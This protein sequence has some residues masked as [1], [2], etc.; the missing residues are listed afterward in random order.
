MFAGNDE[1]L[2]VTD[3]R[4]DPALYALPEAARLARLPQQ[5]LRNWLVGRRYPAG[6]NLIEGLPVIAV[7]RDPEPSLSFIN[8]VEVVAL[9]GFRETGVSMQRV[10]R[11]LDYAGREMRME[12]P[13]ASERILTDGMDLFWQYQERDPGDRHLVNISREGQRVFPE[14]VMRYLQEIEWGTDLFAARWW[15]GAAAQ[16][17]PVVIDPARAFGAP[18]LAGTGIRTEDVF[19]RFRGGEPIREVADDYGI[20]IEQVEAAIRLETK[21][22]EPLAA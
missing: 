9:A 10:R 22:L 17:G 19:H 3:K 21:L 18:V 20:A 8:L 11:A 5:T 16:A 2:I 4:F 1:E 12:H 7:L 13:L 14:A 15:P 6:G